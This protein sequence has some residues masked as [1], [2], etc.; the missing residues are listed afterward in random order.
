[1]DRVRKRPGDE[2]NSDLFSLKKGSSSFVYGKATA[3]GES[4]SHDRGVEGVA[5][6]PARM[7]KGDFVRLSNGLPTRPPVEQ[8]G[9]SRSAP[10]PNDFEKTGEGVPVNSGKST[11]YTPAPYIHPVL[12]PCL[13][14]LSPLK[15]IHI[16]IIHSNFITHSYT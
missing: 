14:P 9:S 3:G 7:P 11:L 12:L 13:T 10:V 16:L 4:I 15:D 8:G 2:L 5:L 1:M 6:T